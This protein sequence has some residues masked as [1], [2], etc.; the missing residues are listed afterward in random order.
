MVFIPHQGLAVCPLQSENQA[1]LLCRKRQIRCTP[2]TPKAC[3]VPPSLI[4]CRSGSF[5]SIS[6]NTNHPPPP[7]PPPPPHPPRSKKLPPL[8]AESVHLSTV[9][10]PPPPLLL[11]HTISNSPQLNYGL[12]FLI[13]SLARSL[14]RSLV[15]S[16]SRC[17]ARAHSLSQDWPGLR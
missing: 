6:L 14:A 12:S 5:Y 8:R 17:R 3:R 2:T 4:L 15:L 7:P 1:Y 9:P 10:S 16:L 11:A 13:N